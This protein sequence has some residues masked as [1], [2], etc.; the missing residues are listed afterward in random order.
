LVFYNKLIEVVRSSAKNATRSLEIYSPYVKLNALKEVLRGVPSEVNISL[1]LRFSVRDIAYG[2]TDFDVYNYAL[3]SKYSVFL[4]NKIHLKTYLYDYS[5]FHT[6]SANCTNSGLGIS[7]SHNHETLSFQDCIKDDYKWFLSSIK[8]ESTWLDFKLL[9]RLS[10]KIEEMDL[11]NE[12]DEDL[13]KAESEIQIEIDNQK[14]ILASQLPTCSSPKELFNAYVSGEYQQHPHLHHDA[15]NF[16]L[17]GQK[18]ASFDD[19]LAYLGPIFF[20]QPFSRR[21]LESKEK[22]MNFGKIRRILEK[23]C[24]DDPRPDRL[25]VNILINNFFGWL[26]AM[27]GDN[28]S[29]AQPN[30]TKIV[31]LNSTQ[32]KLN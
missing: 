18:F 9:H 32:I 22:S 29:I 28:F 19:F 5:Q 21:I 1:I 12:R 3:A 25:E 11:K 23:E 31:I 7:A 10:K 13:K 26:E 17:T 4:N 20:S 27:E 30:H 24:I 2:A 15:S 6:G 16:H 14:S 8:S